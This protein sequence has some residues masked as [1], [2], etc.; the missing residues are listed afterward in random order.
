MAQRY[1]AAI[2]RAAIGIVIGRAGRVPCKFH[3][4]VIAQNYRA[5]IVPINRTTI[6]IAIVTGRAGRVP[7]K[8]H[9]TVV[10][11]GYRAVPIPINRAAIGIG[12]AGLM[13]YILKTNT[14]IPLI[15]DST[16]LSGCNR[17]SILHG[18]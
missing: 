5:V 18:F 8:Y 14:C 1:C 7:C 12:R 17:L 2:N 13:H 11:Q 10:A 16:F 6:A 9:A 15:I 3:A 4:T